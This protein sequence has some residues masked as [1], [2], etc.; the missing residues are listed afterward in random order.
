MMP[1][2]D[3]ISKISEQPE[4]RKYRNNRSLGISRE[5]KNERKILESQSKK[6]VGISEEEKSLN[7][8][9]RKI[10]ES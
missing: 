6:F 5:E 9:R 7:L 2:R 1:W 3:S 10:S 8:R 4:S